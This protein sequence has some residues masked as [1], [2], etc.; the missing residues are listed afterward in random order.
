MLFVPL[1]VEIEAATALAIESRVAASLDPVGPVWV[2]ERVTLR[3]DLKTEGLSFRGQRI[4][5]PEIPGALL[6]E[7]SVTTV[8]L[9]EQ[10]EGE[11]WQVLRYEYPI[12]LQRS[13]R[14]EIPPLEVE[15]SAMAG[16]GSEPESFRSKTP[17]LSLSARVPEGV[18]NLRGLVTT[19]RFSVRVDLEPDPVGL[20]VGDALTRKIVRQAV[21]VTGMAFVPLPV[22]DL[23]GIAVY[24]RSPEIAE[25]RNRG[26]M[27]GSRTD[28]TTY[29]LQQPGSF[30]IPGFE[31]QWW[32]PETR[33]L[34][35]ESVP[36]LEIEVEANPVLS[37]GPEKVDAALSTIRRRP[38]LVAAIG[39]GA[40]ALVVWLRRRAS[41]LK[42][43]LE[44]LRAARREG[45]PARYRALMRACR[46]NE[47]ALAYNALMNWL[48]G[49]AEPEAVGLEE[50]GFALEVARVQG[51]LIRGDRSWVGRPLAVAVR[52]A[53]RDRRR[54]RE[55]VARR[56][57]VALNPDGPESRSAA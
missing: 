47:P 45:E 42:L 5:L 41:D 22:A 40:I 19:S 4:R 30:V 11:T 27:T 31:L 1:L 23:P 38:G 36:D 54:R 2:G 48:N 8:M 26:E 46:S 52:Q 34:R 53:R 33:V 25:T 37:G 49:H 28:S 3:V 21:D 39:L 16:F 24:D 56:K 7:D 6:L 13:G 20:R 17:R 50:G 51:A 15:F 14:V 10:I 44:H 9:S 57:L 12:F 18:A 29:V 55:S 35:S 43:R 32:N